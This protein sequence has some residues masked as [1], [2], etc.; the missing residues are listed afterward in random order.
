MRNIYKNTSDETLAIVGVGVVEAGQE[1]VSSQEIINPNI[2][3]L[4]EYTE[5]VDDQP[6]V[7]D[8]ATTQEVQS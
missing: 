5:A 1:F 2:E 4:G 6:T 3:N 7:N 8:N